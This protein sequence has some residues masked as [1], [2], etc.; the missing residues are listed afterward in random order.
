MNKDIIENVFNIIIST[1]HISFKN[2]KLVN[3]CKYKTSP[4]IDLTVIISEFK[5]SNMIARSFIAQQYF[6]SYSIRYIT[7]ENIRKSLYEME[8][9]NL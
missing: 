9:I 5:M 1:K 7:N 8:K 2:N 4:F 6:Y 3:V